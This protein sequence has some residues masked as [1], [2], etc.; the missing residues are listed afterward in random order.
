MDLTVE[1]GGWIA[2]LPIVKLPN[3]LLGCSSWL[4]GH[5]MPVPVLKP[6]SEVNYALG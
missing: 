2:L 3:N 1:L 4:P 5:A 6:L